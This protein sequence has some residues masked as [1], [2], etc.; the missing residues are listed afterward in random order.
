MIRWPPV[1]PLVCDT[2]TVYKRDRPRRDTGVGCRAEVF[3]PED[4]PGEWPPQQRG[5]TM[6]ALGAACA[7]LCLLLTSSS[8]VARWAVPPEQ[9]WKPAQTVPAPA[10]TSAPQSNYERE[11]LAHAAS[12]R[13]N[14]QLW[15]DPQYGAILRNY[16]QQRLEIA[17]KLDRG[18]ISATAAAALNEAARAQAAAATQNVGNQ[19]AAEYARLVAQQQA[20]QA[21]ADAQRRQEAIETG[22]R[23]LVTPPAAPA[24]A[25]CS[26]FWFAGRWITMCP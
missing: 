8:A 24:P 14:P 20:A 22:L 11:A 17:G 23:L 10:P 4:G 19:A 2:W 9:R 26:T 7:V 18:E 12:T 25:M 1:R 15:G 16:W 13:E 21:A 3:Q 5:G 6:K